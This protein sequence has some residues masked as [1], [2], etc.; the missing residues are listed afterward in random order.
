MKFGGTSVADPE[1]I[2][3]AAERAIAES[4]KGRGVVVVVSA[5]GEM[6]DELLALAERVA[7]EPD[8]RELDQLLSTGEQVAISL[9]AI[10]CRARKAPAVSLTGP[11]AGIEAAGA[12]LKSCVMTTAPGSAARMWLYVL[13]PAFVAVRIGLRLRS[14]ASIRSG[15]GRSATSRPVSPSQATGTTGSEA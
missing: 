9:F 5:P 15:R 3:R 14:A 11:Q 8:E 13:K 7:P 10:A 4:R 1:K 12:M 6:T 2:Q